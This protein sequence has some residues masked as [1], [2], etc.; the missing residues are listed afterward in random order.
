M[1]GY[2]SPERKALQTKSNIFV[3][4][5]F[6]L[7]ILAV[8]INRGAERGQ[9]N[10]IIYPMGLVAWVCWIAGAT[11]YAKS[12][13]YSQWFGALG[14]L[15]CCGVFVLILMPNKWVDGPTGGYG[16]G[17]YPRPNG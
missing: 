12:K 4:A 10:P 6:I 17:D 15:C 11:F 8:V 14:S 13:G 5:A 7:H 16:P 2:I 9:A 3:L 1:A